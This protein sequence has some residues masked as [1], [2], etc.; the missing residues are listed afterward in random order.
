MTTTTTSR[1][2]RTLAAALLSV[3]LLGVPAMTT[4]AGAGVPEASESTTRV[5]NRNQTIV[6]GQINRS[7]TNNRR[8]V[9][10]TN[11]LMNQRAMK[12]AAHLVACQCLELLTQP[13]LDRAGRLAKSRLQY[14]TRCRHREDRMIEQSR[15]HLLGPGVL[16]RRLRR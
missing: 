16:S 10:T 11:G 4:T 9:L 15:R 2:R 5:M 14:A 13:R 3:G 1:L 12:W 8:R 7:R 6:M